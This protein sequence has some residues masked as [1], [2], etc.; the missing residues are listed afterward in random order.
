MP[1]IVAIRF[2]ADVISYCG[3]HLA[4]V[5]VKVCDDR[6]TSNVSVRSGRSAADRVGL[7]VSALDSGHYGV[8]CGAAGEAAL[9]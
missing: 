6:S 2:P 8:R 5:C 3:R 4:G 9:V 7:V 1:S